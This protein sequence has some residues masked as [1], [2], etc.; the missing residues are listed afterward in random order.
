MEYQYAPRQRPCEVLSDKYDR[1]SQYTDE[2]TGNSDAIF[3]M[4]RR[5]A[6]F[7]DM[8]DRQGDVVK[9]ETSALMRHCETLAEMSVV[10]S[11]RSGVVEDLIATVMPKYK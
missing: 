4:C 6:D 9:L 8:G 3:E 1:I 10:A 7:F 5:L 11:Y 2:V